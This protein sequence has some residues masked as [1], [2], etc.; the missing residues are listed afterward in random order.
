LWN[1]AQR[2]AGELYRRAAAIN[3]RLNAA[4]TSPTLSEQRRLARELAGRLSG[5][6]NEFDR[7][8]GRPTADQMARLQHYRGLVEQ[9]E[10]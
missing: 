6:Y 4:P 1:D 7:W 2:T 10:R 8:T 5:M 9:L 3:T